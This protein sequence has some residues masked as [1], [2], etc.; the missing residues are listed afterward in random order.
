MI[1]ELSNAER[2]ALET[3]VDNTSVQ[4]V[5]EALAQVCQDKADHIRA[6]NEREDAQLAS[7][8]ACVGRQMDRTAG[9]SSVWK[10]SP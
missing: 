3:M 5:L 2:D 1:R 6:S 4:R 8:W 9:T 10:V 7:D